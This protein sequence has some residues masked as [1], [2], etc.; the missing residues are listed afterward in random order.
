MNCSFCDKEA[1]PE[2]TVHYQMTGG[3]RH[4][5]EHYNEFESS[6]RVVSQ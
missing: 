5:Q 6:G 3:V 4:C 1:D 2:L